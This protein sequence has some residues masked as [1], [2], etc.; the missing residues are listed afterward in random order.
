[1]YEGPIFF[2]SN[3]FKYVSSFYCHCSRQGNIDGAI[4]PV[5]ANRLLNLEN[6][7]LKLLEW[8]TCSFGS[9]E[10]VAKFRESVTDPCCDANTWPEYNL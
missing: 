5:R 7:L 4:E 3:P 10:T 9:N 8:V 1:M 6:R 2:H